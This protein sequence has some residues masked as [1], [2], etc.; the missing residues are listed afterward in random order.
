MHDGVW[1][2]AGTDFDR[3]LREEMFRVEVAQGFF[4]LTEIVI[5]SGGEDIGVLARPMYLTCVVRD[6]AAM[7]GQESPRVS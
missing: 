6:P 7:G 1:I 5:A 3:N 4:G 2:P